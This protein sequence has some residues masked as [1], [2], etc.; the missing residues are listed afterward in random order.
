VTVPGSKSYTNRAFIAAALAQGR[1][2]LRNTLHSDD[3]FYMTQAL[4]ALGI[5]VGEHSDGTV[6]VGGCAG[7][8]PASA[9]EL[10][11]GNA[12][13]AMRFLT[14][15]VALGDGTYTIDGNER[16]RQRPIAD[17]L[18]GL[19]QLG[20]RA[21]STL[22]TGCPPVRVRANG[23][24][25][26]VV[27]IPGDKSSQYFSAILLAAPYARHNVT[28]EPI[29][30]LVSRP[31]VEM[32]TSLMR[33]FGAD[34]ACSGN[35]MHVTAGRHYT[36][37]DYTVEADA[38]AASYFF[39]A[40]AVTGGRVRVAGLSRASLQ[41]D[42]HFVDA[43][44]RMGCSVA[45]CEVNGQPCIEV[46]GGRL[47]GIKI[48]MGDMSDVALTLAAVAVF[49]EGPTRIYNVENMRIKETD[50]ISALATE[51]RRIG[52]TVEEFRD[53]LLI[54][55]QSITPAAIHTYDDHRMAMSFSV[56][57]LGSPG[58]AIQNPGC[59]AKTFPDFFQ[60]LD[61]LSS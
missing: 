53:G 11:V 4:N 12:G 27:R 21:E 37:T 28:V 36:G 24:D 44:A 7:V 13:T 38:S 33:D 41:G 5:P 56:V 25:G 35:T 29:G 52:Q 54:V 10:Y 18:E 39:A 49:A 16:M 8:I 23:L 20:A 32:T 60:R 55:P 58:I 48:D 6:G 61:R 42:V 3:S 46:R 2:I 50:R 30:P 31:Y 34:A 14:A 40:A 43:L 45:E 15:A 19:A 26:G 47:S 57:G 9:A 59:V 1:S 51:L 17:L 22:N